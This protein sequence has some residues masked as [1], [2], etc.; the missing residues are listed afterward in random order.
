MTFPPALTLQSPQFWPIALLALGLA[1]LV[2]WLYAPTRRG[3]DSRLWLLFTLRWTSLAL[4]GIAALRP[5]VRLAADA[6]ARP[7]LVVLVDDSLSMDTVDAGAGL[8]ERVRL[9]EAVGLLPRGLRADPT[10]ACRQGISELRDA[11]RLVEETREEID[12]AELLG[13]DTSTQERRLESLIDAF[14]R[15]ATDLLALA[16]S[17]LRLRKVQE[18]LRSLTTLDPERTDLAA[19]SIDQLEQALRAVVEET[20]VALAQ[21]EPE[22][23]AAANA[24]ASAS[25]LELV[26]LALHQPQQGV[27]SRLSPRYAIDIKTVSGIDWGAT[28]PA[29]KTATSDLTGNRADSDLLG[30]RNGTDLVGKRAPTDLA[31]ALARLRPELGSS[32]ATVL[33]FSDGRQ[34]APGPPVRWPG[35]RTVLVGSTLPR[36]DV[37][38]VRVELPETV[39]PGAP[40]PLRVTARLASSRDEMLTIL[41]RLGDRQTSRTLRLPANARTDSVALLLTAPQEPAGSGDLVVSVEASVAGEDAVPDNNRARFNVRPLPSLPVLLLGRTTRRDVRCLQALLASE[42]A[43]TPTLI[44]THANTPVEVSDETLQQ[45]E[46]VV[47]ADADASDLDDASWQRLERA[48]RDRGLIVVLLAGDPMTLRSYGG[49]SSTRWLLPDEP[50]EAIGWKTW[51]GEMPRFRVVA[52]DRFGD[53][54]FVDDAPKDSRRRWLSAPR[55]HRFIALPQLRDDAD[56]WLRESDSQSPLLAEWRHGAGCVRWL[57]MSETWR[58]RHA[59]LHQPDIQSTLFRAMLEPR[60]EPDDEL[61]SL[62]RQRDV[63]SRRLVEQADLSADP[64]GLARLD[65]EGNASPV[66]I[67]HLPDLIDE[68]LARPL[69]QPAMKTVVLSSTWPW[70]GLF[71]GCVTLEWSLRKRLG[72]S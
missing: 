1:P 35:L 11:L 45:V 24:V 40:L 6:R 37:S 22:V 44:A 2:F 27:L 20:D 5:A 36:R 7:P 14:T 13:R 57:A 21:R 12:Y 61:A 4:A 55:F 42:P 58:W 31:G 56:V 17:D 70:L 29:D 53:R 19:R 9:A 59:T 33:L 72:L 41:A 63:E 71:V 32:D 15:Q 46:T 60:Q 10:V 3:A 66:T 28:N 34:T 67:D 8:P 38:L 50:V 69:P 26:R 23:A 48:V 54:V 51:A 65:Y 47:L 49:S 52:D 25:R 39:R 30:N 64:T 18:R 62:R 68:L 43:F 16:E